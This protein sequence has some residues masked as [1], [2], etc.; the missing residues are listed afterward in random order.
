M[1]VSVKD[2]LVLVNELIDNLGGEV[3]AQGMEDQGW[4]KPDPDKVTD[5][6]VDYF[7]NQVFDDEFDDIMDEVYVEFY[8]IADA[9]NYK[10]QTTY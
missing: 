5:F 7:D 10:I 8:N 2:L 4:L 9:N 3:V 1:N 6:V